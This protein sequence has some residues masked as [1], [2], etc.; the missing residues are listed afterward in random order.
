MKE[1][2]YSAKDMLRFANF[3]RDNFFTD[4][5]PNYNPYN[6]ERFKSGTTEDVFLYWLEE[7]NKEL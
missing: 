6:R 5:G 7:N 2:K 1:L 3:L 4:G